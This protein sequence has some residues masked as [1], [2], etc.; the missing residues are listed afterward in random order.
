MGS[1]QMAKEGLTNPPN[2]Y[3]ISAMAQLNCRKCGHAWWPRGPR[4]PVVCPR[5]KSYEWKKEAKKDEVI[6][7]ERQRD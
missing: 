1:G 6:P 4:E 7:S 5:C 2:K 3:N